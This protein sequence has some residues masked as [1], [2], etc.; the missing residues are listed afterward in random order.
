MLAKIRENP[1]FVLPSDINAPV[2]RFLEKIGCAIGIESL[3]QMEAHIAYGQLELMRSDIPNAKITI[4]VDA[5][6]VGEW[7]EYL[8][9]KNGAWSCIAYK[10]VKNSNLDKRNIHKGENNGHGNGK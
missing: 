4:T 10:N 9:C 6:M 3:K 1:S 5:G 2:Y 7:K 8:L